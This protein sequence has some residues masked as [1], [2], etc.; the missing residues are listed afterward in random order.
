LDCSDFDGID[1]RYAIRDSLKEDLK[2]NEYQGLIPDIVFNEYLKKHDTPEE[3]VYYI[4]GPKQMTQRMEQLLY[5]LGVE[6]G[7]IIKDE[8]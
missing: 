2:E 6:E 5:S 7:N 1:I 8:L 3:I 4:C